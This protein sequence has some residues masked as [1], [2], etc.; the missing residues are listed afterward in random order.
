M[1]Q[2][3][4]VL[5]YGGGRQTVAICALVAEGKLPRPERIVMADTGR[6]DPATWR[7]LDAHVRPMLRNVGLEVEIASHRLATVDLYGKNGDLL[8]PAFTAGGKLPTLC[9]TEWKQRVVRRY[10]RSLGYGPDRPIEMWLGISLDEIGRAKESDKRWVKHGFPLLFNVTMTKQECIK[11]VLSLGLP[12]TPQSSCW[13]CPH[14]Q[15][16]QW[17]RLRDNDP[18]HWKAAVELDAR[19]RQRD[20]RGGVF[21]HKDRVPL[22]EADLS[23]PPEPESSLFGPMADCNSGHCFV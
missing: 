9:S 16:D 5:S 20:E 10:L 19:I 18:A 11:Y 4:I 3:P 17:A 15:N 6:E 1:K 23:A 2:R 22:S 13:M 7:Y 12:E 8:L 14:R 21:L